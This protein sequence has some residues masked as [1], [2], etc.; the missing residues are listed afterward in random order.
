MTAIKPGIC[1]I[2]FRKFSKE[3]VIQYLLRLKDK[4]VHF[5]DINI[6]GMS[7]TIRAKH[8]IGS[9]KKKMPHVEKVKPIEHD[10]FRE[11]SSSLVKEESSSG[12]NHDLE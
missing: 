3:I 7:N 10:E 2:C 5:N 6:F 8:K 12:Y 1:S 9:P 4:N 11:R